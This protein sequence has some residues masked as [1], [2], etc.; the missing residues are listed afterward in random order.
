MT[1]DDRRNTVRSLKA[2]M[3][4]LMFAGGYFVATILTSL[5]MPPALHAPILLMLC[6]GLYFYLRRA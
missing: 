2:I 4:I 3:C 5:D 6:L 1:N